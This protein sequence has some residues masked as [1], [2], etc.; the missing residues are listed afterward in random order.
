MTRMRQTRAAARSRPRR[1]VCPV[2]R[3][4]P[5]PSR[6]SYRAAPGQL[7]K[8]SGACPGM[9]D[10]GAA[11]W[12]DSDRRATEAYREACHHL[13]RLVSTTGPGRHCRG[14]APP[15]LRGRA[16]VPGVGPG[17]RGLPG[18][19]RR[20][21]VPSSL[22]HT[23]DSDRPARAGSLSKSL[24]RGPEPGG[25][26]RLHP[27]SSPATQPAAG[28]RVVFGLGVRKPWVRHGPGPARIPGSLSKPS[29]PASR[30]VVARPAGPS[31]GPFA[32][33]ASGPCAALLRD[34]QGS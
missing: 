14:P 25:W 28:R 12:L 1:P 22:G 33:V 13:G 3:V 11:A 32:R 17:R 26:P 19:R 8:D 24:Q 34:G 4:A 15:E 21:R 27:I 10:A 30:H 7:A 18:A 31:P 23:S 5:R 2:I 20:C 16:A 29:P 6:A 9:A